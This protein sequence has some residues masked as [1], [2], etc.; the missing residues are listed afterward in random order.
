MVCGWLCHKTDT[1]T[2]QATRFQGFHNENVLIL[3]D[4][5]AGILREIWEAKDKLLTNVNISLLR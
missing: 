2:E 4:E 3:F 1:V 5:A